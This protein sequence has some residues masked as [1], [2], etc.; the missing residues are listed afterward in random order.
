ME[1]KI[2]L[3]FFKTMKILKNK[4][5]STKVFVAISL[6]SFILLFFFLSSLSL[7]YSQINFSAGNRHSIGWQKTGDPFI[8]KNPNLEAVLKG[9]IMNEIDPSLGSAKAPVTITYFADYECHYCQQQELSLKKLLEK[10]RDKVRLVWKDYPESN[11][12]SKSYL[13]A[14]AGRCA[15]EQ[16]KFWSYQDSIY[17]NENNFSQDLAVSLAEKLGL[18]KSSFSDCLQDAEIYK[19]VKDN[20]IEARALD[21]KG[22]PF[23]FINNQE[24]MG[25]TEMMDLEKIIE[26]ELNKTPYAE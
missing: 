1:G 21:I 22:V 5:F 10:Y 25:E 19:L 3:Q 20:I 6:G 17:D 18:R 14:V 4:K 7:K 16:G 11:S 13:A 26:S 9:P 23:I 12:D 15:E 2:N 24:I 8:T